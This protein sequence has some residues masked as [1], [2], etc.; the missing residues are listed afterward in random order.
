MTYFFCYFVEVKKDHWIVKLWMGFFKWRAC[1]GFI[2]WRAVWYS[3]E[4]P[5]YL[6]YLVSNVRS[7]TTFVKKVSAIWRPFMV[8]GKSQLW[9]CKRK[10][11]LGAIPCKI[12]V[13]DRRFTRSIRP[14]LRPPCLSYRQVP[15]LRPKTER[16]IHLPAVGAAKRASRR[17]WP[18][19]RPI[20][21][22][23]PRTSS[24]LSS[25]LATSSPLSCGQCATASTKSS[26]K[27]FR[28][29]SRTTSA[30]LE[31]SCS[32]GIQF[33][34]HIFCEFSVEPSLN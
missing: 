18:P 8:K 11:A 21:W 9:Q 1:R 6:L 2:Q 23:W 3:Q 4:A 25:H 14:G 5:F 16:G 34:S 24:T 13:K 10:N 26:A 7:W 32:W 30:L 12:L 22:R 20:W 28:H 29:H 17:R 31:R 33:Y 19:T 15:S 27:G